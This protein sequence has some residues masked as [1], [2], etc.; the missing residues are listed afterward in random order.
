LALPLL[1]D[2]DAFHH[3]LHQALERE[4]GRTVEFGSLSGRLLPRPGVIGH[5]VVVYD[6]EDFGAEP[7]LYAEEMHCDLSL[8]T[9]WSW[10]LS[11]GRVRLTRPSINLVRNAGGEW[12]LATFLFE[13]AA[14]GQQR[15]P[16]VISLSEGRVN[17]KL[18]LDKQLYALRGVRLRLVPLP[19]Q[20]WRV[21]MQATPFRTDQ[22]LAE[23]GELRVTGEVG[24]GAEFASIPFEVQASYARASLAQLWS[25]A[26]GR[27]P[28]VRATMT[29]NA[30][31]EGTPAAWNLK[32]DATL[33]NL[34]RW[35]LVGPPRNPRWQGEFNLTY[36]TGGDLFEI[37]RLLVRSEQEQSQVVVEGSVGD[38][39]GARRWDLELSADLV[40]PELKEQLAALKADVA[41]QL[42]MEGRALAKLA[43][44]GPPRDWTGEITT[45]ADVSLKIP[46]LSRPVQVSA[47]GL[48]LENGRLELR[49][50]NFAFDEERHL[51]LQ[52]EVSP[53]SRGLPYRLSWTSPGVELE[54]LRRT[55]EAFGWDLSLAG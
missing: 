43:L 55:A 2:L 22:R 13:N 17:F 24:Q 18:G 52:G 44:Q 8:R 9:L 12:N 51:L 30:A 34:H 29:F 32:G 40:L 54:P 31:V 6:R 50:L 27:E 53:F 5:R 33:S 14:G 20:S 25:L 11:L 15:R 46:G 41:A 35:D 36:Q 23:M 47:L 38:L 10:R 19:D 26:M 3:Q 7:F 48:H 28:P 37:Q 39:F 21:D 49:P 16:P 42:Q 45:P 1:L 4:L